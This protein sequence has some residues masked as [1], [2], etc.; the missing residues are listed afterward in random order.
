MKAW[1][2]NDIAAVAI[3]DHFKI[4]NERIK[5]LR[6]LANGDVVIFPGVELRVDKAS[7]NLHVI[8]IF[9]EQEDV[10]KLANDFQVM[11]LD[12]NAK[13]SERDETIYWDFNDVVEYAKT[14]RGIISLHAGK[15]T[16][17]LD[18]C[19]T[20]KTPFEIAI[21][22][23]IST[24][25]GIFEMG[26]KTDIDSYIEHVIPVTGDI[27]M[28]IC[29]DNHDPREYIRKEKLWL[30]ADRTFDGL[31]QVM[32]HPGERV[33]VG[34]IPPKEDI[35]EKR[36]SVYIESVKIKRDDDAKRL[37]SNWF[38]ID[39]PLNN[40][41][42]VV[43]GNK[44]SGKSAF[45]D[46]LGHLC[47]A[48]SMS[49]ASFLNKD[50]FLR[51]PQRYA[52]DYSGSILW[53][54]GKR[55]D[56][57]KLSAETVGTATQYAQ[58]LP[59][60]FIERVCTDL[61]KAFQV[62]I[63]KVIFSYVDTTVRGDAKNLEELIALKSHPYLTQINTVKDELYDINAKLISL[64]TRLTSQYKK[65]I[66]DNLVK[67]KEMLD[68]HINSKPKEVIKPESKLSDQE[69]VKLS[70]CEEKI[71]Q[72]ED[73]I[74][75]SRKELT[76]LN[77]DID[78]LSNVVTDINTV[79]ESIRQLNTK[80]YGIKEKYFGQDV[81][82][83]VTYS[84][85]TE[86]INKRIEELKTR[87]G[88]VEILLDESDEAT[89]KSLY[90]QLLSEK[91]IKK[92]IVELADS[93]EKAY[94]KY[95]ADLKVWNV[96]KA[97]LEGTETTENTVKYYEIELAKI[98]KEYK[99]SYSSLKSKRVAKVKEILEE[100][101]KIVAIHSDVYEPIERELTELLKDMTEKVDFKAN[102]VLTDKSAGESLLKY[103]N[104]TYAGIFNG[105]DKAHAKMES[106]LR[107]TDFSNEA[108]VLE[109]IDNVIKVVEENSDIFDKSAD[110]VKDKSGFYGELFGLDYVGVEFNLN[111]SNR[112]LKELSPGERGIVLLI[113]YLALNQGEEPLIIDQPEDNL[114]NES[115]FKKL[116]PCI[117]EAKKRRQVIIVTHNPNIAIACDAE[118][119]IHCHIDK[120][121]NEITYSAGSIE[122]E[123]I[124]QKIVDV[125]E[126]T[127][128]A[129]ELRSKKY[130][131]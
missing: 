12:R 58:Y 89:I 85:P 103:V 77:A 97:E 120:V 30:K 48:N 16:S 52:N 118:Q 108:S 4:D 81:E 1:Q 102:V 65:E 21:K 28:I 128:P 40:G 107:D 98:E 76:T 74:K 70:E 61:D 75:E 90:K 20:N 36:K 11:M 60:K 68:R 101:S 111:Y 25:T 32:N 104:H 31:I 113:F 64:E 96:K 24:V 2:E 6:T 45:A 71:C 37:E 22:Q 72:I 87:K 47:E 78:T 63:N 125:L 84:E 82:L 15:K 106:F 10:D 129:F 19:I 41:L 100:K 95:L 105:R 26:Q 114:D 13:A 43:I 116:V 92:G 67:T 131:F 34:D 9:S 119:V 80:L 127:K 59:Q 56:D 35:A 62:E 49:E 51:G 124:R 99:D 53:L 94:Q 115:V 27:P 57:V 117:I 69:Q 122:N 23:E 29:S 83:K 130:I 121:K 73:G 46:V 44:G 112:D 55:T 50:R 86:V 17:G 91:A 54:D 8:L 18:K 79:T 3:T 93:A 123:I 5:R 7:K 66:E 39:M 109:F 42:S 38:D 33:F 126:G 14:K 110:I 88:E